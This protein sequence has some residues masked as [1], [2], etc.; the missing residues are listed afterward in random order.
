MLPVPA[1]GQTAEELPAGS[2]TPSPTPEEPSTEP[3]PDREPDGDKNTSWDQGDGGGSSPTGGHRQVS[4]P[5][6]TA[7]SKTAEIDKTKIWWSIGYR[8]A[9]SYGTG[10]IERAAAKLKN[11]GQSASL[12][13]L[14]SPFIIGGPAHWTDTWGVPRRAEEGELRP[15]LGQDVYCRYGD[16][17]LATE[18]G[19]VEFTGDP[20]GGLVAKLHG[21]SGSSFYYGH[22]ARFNTKDLSSGDRVATGDVIGFC[23]RSGNAQTTPA[24]VHF[25]LIGAGNPM[26]LLVD[27]LR[28]A[29]RGATKRLARVRK[30]VLSRVTVSTTR[31]LYGESFLPDLTTIRCDSNL[32]AL[33]TDMD[34]DALELFEPSEEC[35]KP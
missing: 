18:R 34:V 1:S 6:P 14:Y 24:H 31:R 13:K 12:R 4:A 28:A 32:A 16:P 30:R 35:V 3:K 22:L 25:A 27:R 7:V 11:L 10:R 20:L 23:G 26:Q 8:M 2:A 15:H 5:R 33:V 19:T 29:E 17:V 9:G 21:R